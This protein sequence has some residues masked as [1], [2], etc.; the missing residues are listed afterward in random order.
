MFNELYYTDKIWK[1]NRRCLEIGNYF[2]FNLNPF[3]NIIKHFAVQYFNA[4]AVLC[5][6][7]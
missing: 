3:L 6:H 1:Q 2:R 4:Q 7:L 5:S